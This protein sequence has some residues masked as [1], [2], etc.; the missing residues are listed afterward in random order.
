MAKVYFNS[1]GTFNSASVN[2]LATDQAG[3]TSVDF[4]PATNG[5]LSGYV[6]SGHAPALR[7]NA[8]K[9]FFGPSALS[10]VAV[11]APSPA[12]A[13]LQ[14]LATLNTLLQGGT[15]LTAAQQLTFRQLV[16]AYIL[17]DLAGQP[18]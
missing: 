1:D 3:L 7:L 18:I 13:A 2:A 14:Q 10:T 5:I 6:G 9:I 8:G 12:Y 4:D 16:C 15:D 11:V 17:Q